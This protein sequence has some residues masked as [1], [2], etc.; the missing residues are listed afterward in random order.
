MTIG[1]GNVGVF[2][3]NRNDAIILR[4]HERDSNIYLNAVFC[5]KKKNKEK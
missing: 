2:D 4:N 5:Y 3:E 1:Y